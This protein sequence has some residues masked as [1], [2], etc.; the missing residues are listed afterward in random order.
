[1][2]HRVIMVTTSY[3][4]FEGDTVGTFMAPVATGLAARGHEVHVVLPWHP[5]LQRP[6]HE[7]G[8]WFHPY[9]YSPIRRWHVFGYAGALRADV[10]LRATA[11]AVTP[12]A[13]AAAWRLTRQIAE[14][15][16]ATILHGHWVVPGGAIAA[17]AGGA[18]PLVLSLHGSDVFM[19]ERHSAI[20]AVARRVLARADAVIACSEDLRTRAIALGARPRRSETIPYGVD[21]RA[22][23]PDREVRDRLRAAEGFRPDQPIV[24]AIGRFVRKKGFDVLIDAVARLIDRRPDLRLVL[25]GWGDLEQDLR[26]RIARLGID[27][28]VRLP[29]LVPHD[30]VAAWLAAADVV[31]VPSR[32][33]EAGNVDGLPNVVLEALASGTPVVA[34]RAGGIAG[35]IDHERNGLLVS[36]GNPAALAGGIERLLADPAL[37]SALGAAGRAHMITH[38]SWAHIVQRIEAVYD[39]AAAREELGD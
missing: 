2:N 31:A 12:G 17:W 34:T 3:P 6:A 10:R 7:H 26:A 13:V 18:R 22:F 4:R 35:V 30:R 19:A 28:H 29:G 8:I 21:A 23:T 24:F 9:R 39:R 33:D 5:L 38:G 16:D 36:E 15:A 27:A 20:R 32:H 11:L 25:A 1:V 37:A 14:R